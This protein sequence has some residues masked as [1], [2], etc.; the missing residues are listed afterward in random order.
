VG[1]E[2]QF[3]LKRGPPL[4][5]FFVRVA[6]KGLIGAA[7]EENESVRRGRAGRVHAQLYGKSIYV[8]RKTLGRK[9][10]RAEIKGVSVVRLLP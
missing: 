4:S 7:M 9:S 5:G 8:G 2:R 6:G 3:L 1:T 10:N